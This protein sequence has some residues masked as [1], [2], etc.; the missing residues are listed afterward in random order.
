VPPLPPPTVVLLLLQAGISIRLMAS[1]PSRN[2]PNSFLRRESDELIPAPTKVSPNTGT[3]VAKNIPRPSNGF[4]SRAAAAVVDTVRV[5]VAVLFAGGVT[6]A[7]LSEHVG[8]FATAGETLQVRATAELNPAV[9]VTV[10]VA[11][12]E[13][14][15][16]PEVGESA[17]LVIVKFALLAPVLYFAT[18]AS[19]EAPAVPCTGATVGKSVDTVFPAT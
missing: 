16:C 14:P 1:I 9:D 7:G 13:T 17:P 2:N 10:T 6:E 15:A 8:P 5:D 3:M 19:P 12:A 11:L 18:N 4:S